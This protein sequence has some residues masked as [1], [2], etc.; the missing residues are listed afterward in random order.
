M[1]L[2]DLVDVVDTMD[3]VDTVDILASL[4]ILDTLDILDVLAFNCIAQ[5]A[6]NT[7]LKSG[8]CGSCRCCG[9]S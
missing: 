7:L 3:I 1:D 2:V 9:Y 8:S 5:R 6:I 4:D